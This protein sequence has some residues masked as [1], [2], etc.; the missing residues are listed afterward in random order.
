M[1]N[2]KNL[3]EH[4]DTAKPIFAEM[5]RMLSLQYKDIAVRTLAAATLDVYQ[6]LKNH[7]VAQDDLESKSKFSNND[8]VL[9]NSLISD[10]DRTKELINYPV[11][12]SDNDT[13]NSPSVF[14][15]FCSFGNIKGRKSG[16]FQDPVCDLFR[17]RIVSGQVC[18]E[19]EVNQHKEEAED[20][21]EVLQKGFSFIIDTNDEYDVTNLMRKTNDNNI[22]STR[23]KTVTA[24]KDT[25]MNQNLKIFLKTI[26]RHCDNSIEQGQNVVNLLKIVFFLVLCLSMEIIWIY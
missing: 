5:T 17:E 11:H 25:V 3:T 16:H 19:A 6:E 9:G 13:D 26:S 7:Q 10:Y 4:Y 21:T 1:A 14:I 20:W 2:E 12:I 15:P 18:Y 22:E 8:N 24:Y 23:P